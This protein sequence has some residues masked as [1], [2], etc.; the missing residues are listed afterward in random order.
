MRT[1][2]WARLDTE[3]ANQALADGTMAKDLQ[4]TIEGLRP[5]ATYFTPTEG[6]RSCLIVLDL[7]D[8]SQL[9]AITEPF[10]R[11]GAKVTVQPAMNLDDLRKGLSQAS[12]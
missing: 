6:K 11:M 1:L 12:G 7:A 8:P 2:L 4:R 3:K 5:E 10:F 9:P